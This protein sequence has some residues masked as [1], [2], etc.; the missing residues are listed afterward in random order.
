MKNKLYKKLFYLIL[1]S[2]FLPPS[3]SIAEVAKPV[4]QVNSWGEWNVFQLSKIAP[5]AGSSTVNNFDIGD[6]IISNLSPAN[7]ENK[8]TIKENFNS[9]MTYGVE[10][11]IPYQVH[12]ILSNIL[13]IPK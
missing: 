10:S 2:I 3:Y 12:F 6:N 9:K 13:P 8:P 11:P 7:L 4:S 1:L 5:S